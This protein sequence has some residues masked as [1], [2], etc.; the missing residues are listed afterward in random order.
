MCVNIMG[1]WISWSAAAETENSQ[2]LLGNEEQNGLNFHEYLMLIYF[3]ETALTRLFNANIYICIKKNKA[4]ILIEQRNLLLFVLFF[5]NPFNLHLIIIF[6]KSECNT[7][8]PYKHCRKKFSGICK[9]HLRCLIKIMARKVNVWIGRQ[10]SV[11]YAESLSKT[12]CV[13]QL[14]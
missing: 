10:W 11:D 14:R 6:H 3:L 1:P 8:L 4:I 13:T 2:S 5:L 7:W 12:D 9:S